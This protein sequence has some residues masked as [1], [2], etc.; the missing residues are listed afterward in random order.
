MRRSML[1]LGAL[2]AA[3]S[4]PAGAA[5]QV[6]ACE[7]EWAA[8]VAE[9]G[10]DK[11]AVTSA[12]NPRQ[13]PHRIEARPS[14]VARARNADLLVCTGADLEVG[15]LPVLL[16][17]SGNAR[18]QRGQPGYFEAAA[19]VSLIEKPAA[20]DRS[21]GDVHAAGNPHLQ[22]DPRN[23]R[24]VADGLARRLAQVDPANA[25]TYAARGRDFA[26]RWDAALARWTA[27]GSG[28]KGTPVAVQHGTFSYLLHWLG[29]KQVADLEPKPGVDPSV[30]QLM[31]VVEQLKETPPRWVIRAA[32]L[33][34]RA[35][36]WVGQRMG[37]HALKLPHTVDP[38]EGAKDLFGLFDVLL[39]RLTGP[40]R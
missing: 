22:L 20:L 23:V 40:G 35:S 14:L 26:T 7:P 9:L 34:P 5:L 28:L 24:A 27:R 12:T 30:A 6:L 3:L 39:D 18:V 1:L 4:L 17:E 33:S 8:L 13:D 19:V 38:D 25:S 31:K 16:S 10:G 21:M 37:V 29:M 15:W 36:E 11:V 2:L 32:Y